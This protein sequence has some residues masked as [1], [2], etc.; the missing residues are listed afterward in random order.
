MGIVEAKER[1]ARARSQ[2]ER[3]QT[4]A[5]ADDPESV[6]V[7]AFYAYENCVTSLAEFHSRAWNKTHPSKVQLARTLYN[8]GLVSRD[9]SNHLRDLNRLRKDVAYEGPGPDL[10][11]L[12]LEDL[13]GR[14]EDFIDEIATTIGS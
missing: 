14:L 10:E 9:I 2:L 3:V 13:A 11:E 4:A 7:W 6:V 1:I 8:A 12:D 5:S